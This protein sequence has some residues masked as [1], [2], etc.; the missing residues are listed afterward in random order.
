MIKIILFSLLLAVV[1]AAPGDKQLYNAMMTAYMKALENGE[2]QKIFQDVNGERYIAPNDCH[3][4]SE[5]Y[6]YPAT[7][8]GVYKETINSGKLKAGWISGLNVN[9]PDEGKFKEVYI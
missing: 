9:T 4:S 3:V 1:F 8:K 2:Y 7:P 5:A 6:G